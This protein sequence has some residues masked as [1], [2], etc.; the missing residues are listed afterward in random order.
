MKKIYQV[1]IAGG[2]VASTFVVTQQVFGADPPTQSAF[3]PVVPCR[4]VDTRPDS[5]VGPR[6]TPLG[7]T[8]GM[9]VSVWGSNGEC[10]IPLTA[11]GIAMNVT[12]VGGTEP[13]FLTLWPTDAAGR[14]RT[15]NLNWVPGSAPTPNKVDVK[16]A[17]DNGK[18]SMFNLN[19]SV[20]VIADVVGY[21]EPIAPGPVGPQGP[22]GPLG[23]VTIVDVPI[24]VVP[25]AGSGSNGNATAICPPGQRVI[26]GG[27]ENPIGQALNTR[28]SRPSPESGTNPTGWFGD[29]RSPDNLAGVAGVK[30]YALCVAATS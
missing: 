24:T 10:T 11:T 14:P 26:S 15:S 5:Q 8:E 12:A 30:V 21:Y 7:P 22:A 2:L 6:S 29:V 20:D 27:V 23:I 28:S 25:S 17:A 13:S 9:P 4:L 19:G 16:L 3:V 1:A 18:F